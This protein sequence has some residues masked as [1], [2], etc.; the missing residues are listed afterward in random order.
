MCRWEFGLASALEDFNDDWSNSSNDIFNELDEK[1]LKDIEENFIKYADRS[2]IEEIVQLKQLFIIGEIDGGFYTSKIS[3][4]FCWIGSLAKIRNVSYKT[5]Q[6]DSGSLFEQ[7]LLSVNKGD[8]PKNNKISKQVV[9]WID[10][11]L[12][13]KEGT[14]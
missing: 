12:D 7:F 1:D 6:K 14:K 10:K 2:T 5:L 13:S 4:C 3:E 8:T 11:Y 9:E